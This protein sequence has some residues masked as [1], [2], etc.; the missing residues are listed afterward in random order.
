MTDRPEDLNP[1]VD[2]DVC[3]RC[4]KPFLPGHRVFAAYIVL[5]KGCNPTNLRE[6]GVMLTGEYEMIH[7]DCNDPYLNKGLVTGRG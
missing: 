3:G 6:R 7:A 1:H 5:R 4:R 2:S